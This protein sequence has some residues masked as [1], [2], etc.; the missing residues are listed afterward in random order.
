MAYRLTPVRMAIIK[1]TAHNKGWGGC[2]EK[3]TLLHG[4]WDC[5]LVQPLRETIWKLLKKL[6]IEPWDPATSFLGIQLKKAKT[7]NYKL[8][9]HQF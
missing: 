7:L 4:W 3:E 6:K 8:H 2:E 1:K 5:K 9:T